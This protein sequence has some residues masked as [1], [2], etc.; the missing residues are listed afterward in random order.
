MLR[1]DY[2]FTSYT[3]PQNGHPDQG[4]K[5]HPF[6]PSLVPLLVNASTLRLITILIQHYTLGHPVFELCIRGI[7]QYAF[8]SIWILLLRIPFVRLIHIVEHA[9][10]FFILTDEQYFIARLYQSLSSLLLM[11]I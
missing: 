2:L 8:F 5:P 11:G 7:L 3:H 6:G 4:T 10:R 1:F 9:C